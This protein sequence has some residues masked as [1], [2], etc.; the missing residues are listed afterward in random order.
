METDEE[1]DLL[2]ISVKGKAVIVDGSID[3]EEELAIL[4]RSLVKLLEEESDLLVALHLAMKSKLE[5]EAAIMSFANS[6]TTS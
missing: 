4:A 2:K 5:K 3:S 6:K 1:K